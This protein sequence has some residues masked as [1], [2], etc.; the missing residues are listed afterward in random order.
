MTRAKPK[1]VPEPLYQHAALFDG[2]MLG[3][4][5]VLLEGE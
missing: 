3:I 5:A 4:L 2:V 1:F